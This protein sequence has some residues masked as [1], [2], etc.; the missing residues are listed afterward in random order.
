MRPPVGGTLRSQAALTRA[1]RL[2][3]YARKLQKPHLARIRQAPTT[4]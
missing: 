3:G 1:G 4:A 2:P